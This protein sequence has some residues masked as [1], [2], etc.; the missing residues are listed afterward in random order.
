[1]F[2]PKFWTNLLGEVQGTKLFPF[3][4]WWCNCCLLLLSQRDRYVYF[5]HSNQL[6]VSRSCGHNITAI[7]NYRCSGTLWVPKP[8]RCTIFEAPHLNRTCKFISVLISV[9][10]WA[11]LSVW[12]TSVREC[13]ISKGVC[14][15]W[16]IQSTVQGLLDF[17]LSLSCVVRLRA[18]EE[19]SSKS[20]VLQTFWQVGSNH[21]LTASLMEDYAP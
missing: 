1:M 3:R 14:C 17:S 11:L 8:N 20:H 2:I 13:E 18:W 21:N 4:H 6:R 15:E 9:L 12:K 16:N 10:F 19:M 7:N 5:I